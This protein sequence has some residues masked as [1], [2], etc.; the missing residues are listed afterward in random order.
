M[1]HRWHG[2]KQR[3]ISSIISNLSMNLKTAILQH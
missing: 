3:P 2:Q 1:I